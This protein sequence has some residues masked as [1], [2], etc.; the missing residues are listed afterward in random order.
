MMLDNNIKEKIILIT[1]ATSGI[2]KAMVLQLAKYG[3]NVILVG[4]NRP[5]GEKVLA[6][7]KQLT[8]NG[9]LDLMTADLSQLTEVRRLASEFKNRYDHLHILINNAGV[10]STQ[11]KITKD[12][13]ELNFAVN[14][15]APFL[16]THLLL[17][18]L[19]KSVPSRIINVSSN[20]HFRGHIYFDDLQ[21]ERNYSGFTAYSQSKLA[22]TMF[23]YDL[24]DYLKGTGVTVN[25]FSPGFTKTNLGNHSNWY[26]RI[27][28]KIVTLFLKPP[29][30][31]AETGVY[32]AVSPEVQSITGAYFRNKKQIKSSPE[33]Y[34]KTI[35]KKLWDITKAICNLS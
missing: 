10:F 6:E 4:R 15:L 25:C 22:L 2:G 28:W 20:L 33:T 13:F 29:E 14:Y 30:K 7:L 32:L 9:N 1:G 26:I 16:L 3:A 11:R 35:R 5:K 18:L 31:G 17:D 34:D 8:G 19:K 12:G 21:L 24:A 27:P 23:T